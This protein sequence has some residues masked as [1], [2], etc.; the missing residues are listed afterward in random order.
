LSGDVREQ[1]SIRFQFS[2]DKW[3][4]QSLNLLSH[5]DQIEG[6]VRSIIAT[7]ILKF[8]IMVRGNIIWDGQVS[9]YNT[10]NFKDILLPI[11]WIQKCRWI[12]Q[13]YQVNPAL[14]SLAKV[15]DDKW[16]GIEDLYFLLK[17][18]ER[19][20]PAPGMTLT[21]ELSDVAPVKQLDLSGSLMMTNENQT[22]DFFGIQVPLGPMQHTFNYVKFVSRTPLENG[23]ERFVFA[24]T[25]KTI[26]TRILL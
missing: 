11:E 25:D 16:S 18:K 8:Q 9:D 2:L 1:P 4:G 7:R 12:A 6:F 3:T 5:F 15:P 22:E 23:E 20:V 17:N 19:S 26:Q 21:Y 14:P 10:G 24:T 13:H